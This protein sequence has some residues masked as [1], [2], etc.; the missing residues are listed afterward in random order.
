V[1]LKIDEEFHKLHRQLE[2]HELQTLEDNILYDKRVIDPIIVW[3]GIILDGEHRWKIATKFNLPYEVV[4]LELDSREEAKE[5][6][7]TH[8]LGR[9]NLDTLSMANLRSE[10]AR[11]YGGTKEAAKRCSV[12]QRTIQ[13]AVQADAIVKSF[14]KDIREKLVARQ[15]IHTQSDLNRIAALDDVTREEVIET[16]RKN[17]K[18][19]LSDVI[20]KPKAAIDPSGYEELDQMGVSGEVRQKIALGHVRI[21]PSDIETLR[22]MNHAQRVTVSCVLESGEVK[23]FKE[24]IGIVVKGVPKKTKA[25]AD[26]GR[27]SEAAKVQIAKLV[28]LVDEIGRTLGDRSRP[29]RDDCVNALKHFDNK[30]DQW[31][32][33]Y[34]I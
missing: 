11:A 26:L 34:K 9:R 20:P 30:L 10:V 27:L 18:K 19:L 33:R 29:E 3:D 14:P 5:W 23:S 22:K 7:L 12:T 31:V 2:P 25:P 24:A 21:T 15:I 16:L 4:E 28:Q 13:R 6:I 17:P 32:S 1:E 8:Q